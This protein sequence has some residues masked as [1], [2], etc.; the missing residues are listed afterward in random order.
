MNPQ[1]K[2]KMQK[3]LKTF[4]LTLVVA[5]VVW[6]ADRVVSDPPMH[7]KVR[8]V[9]E[10]GKPVEGAPA[11]V[12]FPQLG[13]AEQHKNTDAEGR[14]EFTFGSWPG[15]NVDVL[16]G[17]G[18]APVEFNGVFFYPF[19]GVG[20]PMRPHA[21][22]L[23]RWE[24]WGPEVTLMLKKVKH[25]VPL[26]CAFRH[27]MKFKAGLG[28][29][30]GYDFLAQDWVPPYGK[31]AVT[32]AYIR[33]DATDDRRPVKVH[34]YSR[35]KNL[36][37]TVRF[38]NEG[39]GM[40]KFPHFMGTPVTIPYRNAGSALWHDHEAPESGYAREVT[41]ESLND[42]ELSKGVACDKAEP[43][44]YGF[45]A[46]TDKDAF[47]RLLPFFATW[48]EA[49]YLKIRTGR[50]EPGKPSDMYAVFHY[51]ITANWM[52]GYSPEHPDAPTPC[53][54]MR[55]KLNPARGD[56]SL[57]WNGVNL[58]PAKSNGSPDPWPEDEQ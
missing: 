35:M 34:E 40:I 30:M 12:R 11:H 50:G 5:G 2:Q 42:E 25:P 49:A 24:P 39:D 17:N 47:A 57:E 33:V 41:F 54:Q 1:Q 58:L 4:G 21:T 8:V 31:G 53:I 48:Q 7:I 22:K 18:Y 51:G 3:I 45:T 16:I 52:G 20:Y 28:A 9:D 29:E 44:R 23:S 10:T 56:R 38:P 43:G 13:R 46:Y 27:M 32:D 26:A 6:A 14:A 55:Y 15:P 36:R 37:V 19:R